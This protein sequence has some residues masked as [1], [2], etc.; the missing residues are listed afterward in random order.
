MSWPAQADLRL[1]AESETEPCVSLYLPLRSAFAA[2]M[3]NARRY[4]Q[5]VV[6][7]VDRLEAEGVPMN[8]VR[9]WATLLTEFERELRQQA[10]PLHG[11]G[12][13]LDEKALRAYKL[14]TPPSERVVVGDCF[15]LRELVRQVDLL[16]PAES[17]APRL[18]LPRDEK[19]ALELDRIL[20]AAHHG[21]IKRLWMREGAMLVG[22][23]DP[24]TGRIVSAGGSDADVLD[25]LAVGV[26]RAGGR[27]HVVS[28]KQMPGPV[29]TAAELI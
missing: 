24:A 12:L 17:D 7:A 21:R 29:H 9:E 26:L 13:F 16:R 15:S 4:G 11:V 22:R 27:V 19:L 2:S 20:V 14:A 25:A 10:R 23:I 18:D 5:A 3:E 8:T 28:R 1:L 6:R